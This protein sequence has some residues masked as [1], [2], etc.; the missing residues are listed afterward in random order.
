[1]LE[2]RA[3]AALERPQAGAPFGAVCAVFDDLPPA[4]AVAGGR[5]ISRSRNS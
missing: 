5:V 2:P 4:D 1:V 3:A